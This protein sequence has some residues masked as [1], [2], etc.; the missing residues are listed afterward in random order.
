MAKLVLTIAAFFFLFA[1]S[2]ARTRSDLPAKETNGHD[3]SATKLPV[4]ESNP[5]VTLL[6]PSEKPDSEPAT[7]FQWEHDA[8]DS[9]KLTDTDGPTILA[10]EESTEFKHSETVPLTVISFRPINRHFPRRPFPLS[11][12]HGHRCRHGHRQFGPWTPRFHGGERERDQDVVSYG[13]DMI[14][15]SG[16]DTRFVPA[17]HGGPRQ[18]PARWENFRHG[19]GPGFPH[20]HDDDMEFE[21]PHH[22]HHHRHRH[23]HD[24]DHRREEFEGMEN[25]REH[26]RQRDGGLFGRFRKFLNHF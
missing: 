24:H 15:S 23:D 7:F 11:F 21:R 3:Q 17:F 19:G 25:P 18:I 5:A 6:L 26:R 1:F 20:R 2:H 8:A 9:S 14:L 16:D 10:N 4:T 22:H 13:D 12:R